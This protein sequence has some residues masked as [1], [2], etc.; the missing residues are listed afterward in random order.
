M[1]ARSSYSKMAIALHWAVAILV[2][3]NIAGGLYMSSLFD[4]ELPELME[5]GAAIAAIHKPVG[6]LVLLLTL[7]RLALRLREPTFPL[8]SHMRGWEVALARSTHWLFY[9]LLVAVP[10]FGWAFAVTDARPLSVFGLF[11]VPPLPFGEAARGVLHEAHEIGGKAMLG[12]V[13]LH[14]AGALKHQFLDRDDVVARMLPFLR[15][16]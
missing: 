6:I 3:G 13:L 14:V 8:P 5:Q 4:S 15:R 1:D 9:A 16:D 10:L 2:L 12:L 7:L 11:D